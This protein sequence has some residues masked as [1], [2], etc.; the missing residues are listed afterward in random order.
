MYKQLVRPLLFLFDEEVSHRWAILA[1]RTRLVTAAFHKS[2]QKFPSALGTKI[3]GL[4]FPSPVGLAAGFDKDCHVLKPMGD[5][6]FGFVCGG[7]VTLAPRPGNPK[8]RLIRKPD[9]RALV[10]A[11]GFPSDGLETVSRRID[12]LGEFHHRVFVSISG[13]IEDEILACYRRLA[14]AVA[15][16]EL[17]ISSPNTAGL[18]IFH[19]PARL[20]GLLEQ[21]RDADVHNTPVM[22]KLPPWSQNSPER[23]SMLSLVETSVNA[24]ADGLVI[25][26]TMLVEE[27]KIARGSG[28]LSGHPLTENTERM[29]AEVA[30]L[31]GKNASVVSCGGIGRPEDVWRML[32]AGASAVQLYTA[33][34]YEGPGLADKLN[35]GLLKLMEIAGIRNVAD[36]QGPP[37]MF[38][39]SIR[40]SILSR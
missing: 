10:N 23:R 36:I 11:F 6:G 34:I 4:D 32:A 21:I 22:V 35:Q 18:R 30:A 16:I 7:T 40:D 5:L 25:A 13:L 12:R 8:P 20:R 39:R 9:Q 33:M 26:N 31:V 15:G 14:P 37:P 28:G 29:T 17:N 27:S 1:L 3:A 38:D 24:G 19:E 2:S